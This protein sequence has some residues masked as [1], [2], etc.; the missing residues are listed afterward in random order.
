MFTQSGLYAIVGTIDCIDAFAD[1]AHD[2]R[3][4]QCDG[5]HDAQIDIARRGVSIRNY[6]RPM[7]LWNCRSHQRIDIDCTLVFVPRER[8]EEVRNLIIHGCAVGPAAAPRLADGGN[9]ATGHAR[10]TP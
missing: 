9:H 7:P 10:H 2:S 6:S 5:E 3:E 8:A 4:S 1:V